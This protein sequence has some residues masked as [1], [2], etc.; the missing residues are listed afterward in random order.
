MKFKSLLL[1]FALILSTNLFAKV[2]KILTGQIN[3]KMPKG[4]A[5]TIGCTN[6]CGRF[7]RWAMKWYARKLG[8]KIKLV[9]LRGRN[10][11]MD[12]TQVD[13]VLIPGGSDIDPKRYIDKVT[14]EMKEHLERLKHLTNYSKIGT[15]RD[16]FE[17]DLLDKYFKNPNQKYQPVL[18]ICRGMQALTVSQGIPLYVDIKTELGIKNR[19]YTLDRVSVINEESL[20]KET[21][22]S[23]SFRGVE[24]HHQGLNISYFNK[25]RS[26]WPNLDVTAVSNGGKIAEAIEFY[27]RPVFGVQFHPEYTFGKVRRGVFKWLLKRACFNNQYSKKLLASENNTK[28]LTTQEYYAKKRK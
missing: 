28:Q 7:N 18:G 11:T 22:R 9:N 21:I 20:V 2:P 12:Y 19:R 15:I 27:D 14:P 16:E 25:H 1:L 10:Q 5:I 6:N 8:Y 13:G 3:C 23:S 17:F 24:L 4:E 26:N